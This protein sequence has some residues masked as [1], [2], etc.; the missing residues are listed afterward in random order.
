LN[1]GPSGSPVLLRV[2]TSTFGPPFF[3]PPRPNKF[4]D[5]LPRY[6]GY[7]FNP[8]FLEF[9]FFGTSYLPFF[10]SLA[11][12]GLALRNSTL[13]VEG[14]GTF[15]SSLPTV[16]PNHSLVNTFGH[17]CLLRPSR[18]YFFFF[19]F[20]SFDLPHPTLRWTLPP[21]VPWKNIVPRKFPPPPFLCSEFS[22]FFFRDPLCH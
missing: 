7:V 14:K 1:P 9:R 2:V 3:P 13:F 12:V 17:K 6:N 20:I 11:S 21:S 19:L 15:F 18:F 8:S 4:S 16:T 22:P 10:C 5:W